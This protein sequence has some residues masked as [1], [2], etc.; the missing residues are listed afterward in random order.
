MVGDPT[1]KDLKYA[2]QWKV[3]EC[4]QSNTT[5]SSGHSTIIPFM[6]TGTTHSGYF[7]SGTQ[8]S[9]ISGG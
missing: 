1:C 5:G 9:S 8:S 3:E 2:P 7:S 6:N 4:N